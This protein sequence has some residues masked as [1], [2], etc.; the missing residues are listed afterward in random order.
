MSCF[1]WESCS[2]DHCCFSWCCWSGCH[3]FLTWSWPLLVLTSHSWLLLWWWFL[4]ERSFPVCLILF[5]CPCLSKLLAMFIAFSQVVDLAL[6]AGYLFCQLVACDLGGEFWHSPSVLSH[7]SLPQVWFCVLPRVQL[8]TLSYELTMT[9]PHPRSSFSDSGGLLFWFPHLKSILGCA[10]WFTCQWCQVLYS[11]RSV[12]G[13]IRLVLLWLLAVP[14][15]TSLHWQ[16]C[17]HTGWPTLNMISYL[18]RQKW[19]HW[20]TIPFYILLA[21]PAVCSHPGMLQTAGWRLQHSQ[22]WKVLVTAFSCSCCNCCSL[23]L[24]V[25]LCSCRLAMVN[26][27]L[28]VGTWGCSSC[29]ALSM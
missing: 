1:C 20:P 14:W 10:A 21:L 23:A 18:F 2:S 11:G 27:G 15:V 12:P 6:W 13:K 22:H 17:V 5:A 8:H 16:W 25:I 19:I 26:D 29:V 24:L 4:W 28:G 3:F 9:H 7:F